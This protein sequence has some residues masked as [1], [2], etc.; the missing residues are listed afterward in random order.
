MRSVH[1]LYFN[2]DKYI[3]KK[4]KC[5]QE[6]EAPNKSQKIFSKVTLLA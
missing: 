2:F 4:K 3:Y 1:H 5:P 6:L